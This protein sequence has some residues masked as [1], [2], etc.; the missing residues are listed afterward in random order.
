[1]KTVEEIVISM[2]DGSPDYDEPMTIETARQDVLNLKMDAQSNC[3]DL[4]EDLT[5][6]RYMEVYNELLQNAADKDGLPVEYFEQAVEL[7][8]D[9]LR[10]EIHASGDYDGDPEGFL[11]EYERRHLEKYGEAFRI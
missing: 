8:D 5:P 9:D 4:P 7:M 10:E 1:M 3:E 11:R 2:M 6:E